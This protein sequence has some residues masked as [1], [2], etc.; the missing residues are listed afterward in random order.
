MTINQILVVLL[1]T[2]QPYLWFLAVAVAALLLAFL[3]GRGR[4]GRRSPLVL[5]TSLVIGVVAALLAPMLTGSQLVYV[6]TATDWLALLAI[7][8]AVTLYSVLLLTPIWRRR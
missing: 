2:I 3:L 6:A 1:Y 7:A 8:L 4:G 5:P